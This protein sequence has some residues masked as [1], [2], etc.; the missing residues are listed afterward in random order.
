MN[1]E[2]EISIKDTVKVLSLFFAL[3]VISLVLVYSGF[4]SKMDD[5]WQD[6][7]ERI[8]IFENETFC[9]IIDLDNYKTVGEVYEFDKNQLVS[10]YIES[11]GEINVF[12]EIMTE[13]VKEN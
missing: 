3:A 4:E 9:Q 7:E 8:T 2:T 12:E 6:G 10:E 5:V 13:Q 1:N 11:G